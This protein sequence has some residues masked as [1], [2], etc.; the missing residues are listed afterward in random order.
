VF[1]GLLTFATDLVD[2]TQNGSWDIGASAQMRMESID[3]T[4]TGF[5]PPPTAC[6]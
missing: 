2:G 1:F 6:T 3:D 5:A 4:V